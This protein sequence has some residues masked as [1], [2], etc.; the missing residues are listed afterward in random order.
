MAWP[1]SGIPV[2]RGGWKRDLRLTDDAFRKNIGSYVFQCSLATLTVFIVLIVLDASLQTAIID[3]LGASSFIVFTA[4][5]AFSARTRSLLGGY[6]V[7]MTTGI[8]CS[9]LAGVLGHEGTS[10]WSTIIIIMGSLAVGLSIFLMV[11]TDTE[12]PPAA[13][14]ALAFI[15][16]SWN[17]TT[18]IVVFSAPILLFLM[19]TLFKKYIRDL[20]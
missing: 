13:G 9:L 10:D 20:V 1:L 7:G 8:S 3:S 18:V 11:I 12:H 6:A 5:N 19:K 16:N 14:L 4:P 15:L 17:F 2:H